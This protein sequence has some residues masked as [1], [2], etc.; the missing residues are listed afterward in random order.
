[1]AGSFYF[2][3]LTGGGGG[4]GAVD[5][6]FGRT[7]HVVAA[8]GDYT[9]AQVTNA[10]STTGSYANPAWITSLG[11]PKITGAPDFLLTLNGLTGA[12]QTLDTGTSGSN[13][14]IVSSG[15]THTFNIPNASATNRGLLTSADWSTFNAKEPP[16]SPGTTAQY[17]GGDKTW[18][19]FPT[20]RSFST[21]PPGLTTSNVPA[22]A[23]ANQCRFRLVILPHRITITRVGY[24]IGTASAGGTMAI[25]IYNTDGNLIVQTGPQSTGS[26]GTFTISLTSTTL[27]PGEYYV[28][29][30]ADNTTVAIAGNTGNAVAT[31]IFNTASLPT[32]CSAAGSYSNVTGMP[33]S[34]N[35]SPSGVN[36][37][38]LFTFGD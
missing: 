15:S 4:G 1:M 19:N 28:G 31:A 25:G 21:L 23:Y 30:G 5:S 27:E 35:V 7:G 18:R 20:I 22:V 37:V 2:P 36:P 11:W 26:T 12:S 24:N 10:V 29:H 6:V 13:F 38:F 33:S 8:A 16:I 34:F 9:A 17:W 32:M 14:N 3:P